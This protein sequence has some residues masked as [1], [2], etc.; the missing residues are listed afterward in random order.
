MQIPR[1]LKV[2]VESLIALS[3]SA[4]DILA[5]VL[6]TFYLNLTLARPWTLMLYP[7]VIG[8]RGAINGVLS[9]KLSTCLH[10]GLIKPTIR[11]NTPN[12]RVIISSIFTL[13]FFFSL[14]IGLL[15]FFLSSLIF[16]TG[17]NE[18]YTIVTTCVMIQGLSVLAT[19]PL[20][21]LQGFLSFKKGLNPD[22]LIYPVSSTIADVLVTS[23]YIL[24]LY[25]VFALQ[26]TGQTF[27]TLFTLAY[28]FFIL[29]LITELRNEEKYWRTVKEAFLAVLTA[30]FLE[31]IAGSLLS[32]IKSQFERFPG[33]LLVYP[34]LMTSLGDLGSM[35]GSLSTTKLA[36]GLI[37]P[38]LSSITHQKSELI[39]LEISAFTVYFLYGSLARSGWLGLAS[40]MVCH[41]ITFPLIIL[42]SFYVAIATFRGGLDPDNFTI[43]IEASV[44]DSLITLALSATLLLLR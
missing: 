24:T 12:Y 25:L 20:T 5:G 6:I 4:G 31:S 41:L 22:I 19:T 2:L 37:E 36:Y 10:L 39:Q 33:M 14:I 17:L 44:S 29:S 3:F 43:P 11:K 30:V 18:F 1:N 40:V 9:G 32:G 13:S 26:G 21:S 34:A 23:C 27:L 38:E 8:S 35:F 7:L 15:I 16:R 28:C 42:F